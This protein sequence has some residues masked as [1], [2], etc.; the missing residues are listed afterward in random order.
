MLISTPCPTDHRM[1]GP[2]RVDKT[3]VHAFAARRALALYCVC[4]LPSML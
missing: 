3:I 2:G 4:T 1:S